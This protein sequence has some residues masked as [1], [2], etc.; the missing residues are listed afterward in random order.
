M[1][2]MLEG[3]PH[4]DGV[5]H[6]MVDA[7]G[8]AVHVAEAGQGDPVLMMHGWPQHWYC[9]R[10]VI[11]RLAGGFRIICPDLRGFGWTQAPGNGY[12]PDT[13]TADAVALLDA[14]DIERAHVMG[15]DWGGFTTF[16]LGIRHP[17]RVARAIAIN[18]PHPWPSIDLRTLDATWRAWYAVALATPGFGP[19]LLRTQPG[20]VRAFVRADN[21]QPDAI[22]DEAAGSFAQR[23]TDPARAEASSQLYRS[24]LTTF[25]RALGGRDREGRLTVP[26]RLLFGARDLGISKS[27]LRGYEPHA[28]DMEVELVPDSGHFLPDEN[29]E[30]V[31]ERALAFFAS[32]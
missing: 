4:V 29:P 19:W 6:R 11:P 32:S 3:L 27:L 22:P 15:H 25:R 13:F 14:L 7:G 31:A 24:Y 5:E 9:W 1:P 2:Q 16:L 17:D 20:F 26:L 30:L 10:G 8:L 23:L 28:D 18:A 12:D 21:V